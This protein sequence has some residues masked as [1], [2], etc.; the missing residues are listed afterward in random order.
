[1]S[2]GFLTIAILI[3]LLFIAS[4]WTGML[5]QFFHDTRYII[6]QGIDFFAFYQAGNNA[7]NGVDIYSFP[8]P[9]TVPYMFPYRYLAYFAY[10]F[11]AIFNLV[12][13]ILAYWIWIGILIVSVWLAAFRT[14]SVS[15]ALHRQAWEWRIAMGMWF[16]FT[17]IYIELYLGQVTLMAGIL[18]FFALTTP[19]IVKGRKGNWSMT[20][21][22]IVGA[23]MKLI[24]FFIAPVLYGAG[25]VRSILVAVIIFVL[26]I[27]V[28][29]A[30]LE[31]LQVFFAINSGQ[32]VYVHPYVG[33][34]SLKMLLYYLL[35]EPGSDFSIITGLLIGIFFVIS[36]VTTFYSR[37]VWA[38]A[39]LFSLV[40]FF[41][42]FHVWE[43]HYTFLLPL[44]VLAWIRGRPEDKSRWVPLILVLLMSL[45]MLPIV[46]LL[47]GVSTGIDPLTTDTLWLIVYHS[48]KVLPALAFYGFL[49]ILAFRSPRKVSFLESARDTYLK[50]WNSLVLGISP[51]IE[52]G[53]L[54]QEKEEKSIEVIC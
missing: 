31:T 21:F 25:R 7:L 44:L 54:V 5:N 8:D 14:R 26:A 9:L 39:G 46:E 34:H 29:P 35:G 12:P 41:I 17:P 1:M 22:W 45:P 11:G 27:L 32:L 48:S 2:W 15:K 43:H 20:S 24:P 49:L 36:I 19:S 18:M 42:M 4:L 40:F 28:V 51:T 23:L 53:I 6:D 47:S 50:A 30:G 52:G 10:T 13:P 37:D 16:V 33:N 38:C 3:H